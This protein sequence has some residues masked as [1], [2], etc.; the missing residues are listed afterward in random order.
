[1]IDPHV[2]AA[3]VLQGTEPDLGDDGAKLARGRRDTVAGGAVTSGKDFTGDN[4]GGRVGAEVEE[5]LGQSEE[6]KEE[7]AGVA[8]D[9]VVAEAKDQEE[10]CQHNKATK[11]DR[12]ATDLINSEHGNPVT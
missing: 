7:G 4:E 8:Q 1:M 9:C 2:C 5:Q 3:N 6:H 10:D 12:L 11:L